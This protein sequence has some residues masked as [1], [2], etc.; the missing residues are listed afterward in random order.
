MM[1][2]KEYARHRKCSPAAV[3]KALETGRIV[4]ERDESGWRIDA[5]KADGDW[6]RN[7]SVVPRNKQGTAKLDGVG[8]PDMEADA[9]K[10]SPQSRPAPRAEGKRPEVQP[11]DEAQQKILSYNKSLEKEK[12]YKALMAEIEYQIE[13]GALVRKA[14]NDKAIFNFHR[15]IR[16]R[17]LNIPDRIAAVLAGET[18]REKV[19]GILSKELRQ[20]LTE[21]A[22]EAEDIG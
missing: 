20:A 7:T 11:S 22:S 9:G 2:L 4:G 18:D 13:V 12:H 6:E 17:L 16:D 5:N 19:H 10:A 14:D 1:T 3:R 21:L 8:N 15:S